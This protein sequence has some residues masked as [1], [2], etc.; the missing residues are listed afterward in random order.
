V[1]RLVSAE[2]CST[3]W[4]ATLTDEEVALYEHVVDVAHAL[5]AECYNRGTIVPGVT[6]VQDLEWRYWQ[7]C[8]DH[9]LEVAFKPSFYPIRRGSTGQLYGGVDPV[10][11]AG[12]LI[13][14]DVGIRYLGLISDHQ[15][16]V[17]A[18]RPGEED[19]PEGVRALMAEGNRL[20]DAFMAEFRRGLTGDQLLHNIL[21]R[22]RR[23][24]IPNPKIYSH[25]LGR[26][27]HE[28]GPLIGLPW[29]QERNVGRG[30]V[31]LEH[32]YAF[33]ME[34]SV[35]GPVPEWGGESLRF[36]LEEDVVFTAS[37]CRLIGGRQKG[38]FL[39]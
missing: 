15:E 1:E 31:R 33:T 4:L 35:E 7:L 25:S 9:G 32:N 5:M 20:Q 16:W 8:A 30:D 6:T 36:A 14:C 28:P 34:L 26:L 17:Y 18:L 24:G 12:D 21:G 38:F 39:V 11:R 27:L 10:I 23:E 13:R 19:A 2:A 3:R 29:E 22:A 37:G